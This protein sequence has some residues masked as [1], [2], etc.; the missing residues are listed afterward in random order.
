MQNTSGD[1][2]CT[3]ILCRSD[4]KSLINRFLVTAKNSRAEIAV[5]SYLATR[6][7]ATEAESPPL[8]DTMKQTRFGTVPDD[9]C[10]DNDS[11]AE[12]SLAELS[13]NY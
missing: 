1:R 3:P 6:R 9:K 2:L 7:D 12:L 8:V 11:N 4:Q 5:S 13:L 10:T